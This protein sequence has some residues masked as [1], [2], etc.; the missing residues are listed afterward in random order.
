MILP[1]NP[2]PPP[3]EH[4]EQLDVEVAA[5]VFSRAV[6]AAIAEAEASDPRSFPVDG[7]YVCAVSIDASA[8]G[9]TIF[10]LHRVELLGDNCELPLEHQLLG[11]PRVDGENLVA[12]VGVFPDVGKVPP[13]GEL[14]DI[15]CAVTVL[16][17]SPLATPPVFAAPRS[18]DEVLTVTNEDDSHVALMRLLLR[19]LLPESMRASEPLPELLPFD[20]P[21]IW[22]VVGALHPLTSTPTMPY[23]GLLEGY[24]RG[25][26]V[27]DT[28][29]AVSRDRL[30]NLQE[31]MSENP[32]VNLHR[33]W[34]GRDVD[35]PW[36]LT[37]QHCDWL[38]ED[39]T[40]RLLTSR[41]GARTVNLVEEV[42]AVTAMVWLV[43]RLLT[44]LQASPAVAAEWMAQ[45]REHDIDVD[46]LGLSTSVV[47]AIHELS[48]TNDN[49]PLVE[50]LFS[51]PALADI[52]SDS[53]GMLPSP[54]VCDPPQ[55]IREVH[56]FL[57]LWAQ[58]TSLT[59]PGPSTTKEGI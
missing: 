16:T 15:Q 54:M 32:P 19:H 42:N 3:Q 38:G 47:L 25:E 4:R 2:T 20:R 1:S 12:V 31:W 33:L 10:D 26:P 11:A 53:T 34:W 22:E 27:A 55:R 17:A 29:A 58:Y 59:A 14:E 30:P 18:V 37:P 9:D 49:T 45:C 28:L 41:G 57:T 52:L 48:H 39:T 24:L 6:F 50:A 46:S 36:E 51:V 13:L 35:D 56:K 5:E 43:D 8:P 44:H 23:W 40:W 21:L 7:S